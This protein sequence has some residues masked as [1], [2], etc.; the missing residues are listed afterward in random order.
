MEAFFVVLLTAAVLGVGVVALMAMSR[1]RKKMDRP[2]S[3]E[4]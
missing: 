2:D 1:M 4:R 3:Q